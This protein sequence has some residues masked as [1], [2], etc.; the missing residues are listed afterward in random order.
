MDWW[1]LASLTEWNLVFALIVLASALAPFCFRADLLN[2]ALA[3]AMVALGAALPMFPGHALA[4]CV[5]VGPVA[6]YLLLLG[7][8][9]LSRR[10]RVISGTRDMAA[11][12]LAVAGLVMVGPGELL[13]PVASSIR[14]GAFVWV[15]LGSMYL[16]GVVLLL[17][18]LRPR[19]VIYNIS[20]DELRPVLAEVVGKLDPDARWAQDSLALPGQGIQL[21]IES[22]ARLRNVSLVSGGPVQ[23]Y[24]GWR[25]LELALTAALAGVEVPRNVRAMGLV[26]AGLILLAFVVLTVSRDP[27]AVAQAFRDAIHF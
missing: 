2:L 12:C 14:L 18:V 22:L 20:T 21:H 10:P 24:Q 15:L 17:L 19:L 26:S 5:A 8:I 27:Q 25:R 3:V 23:N 1:N 11:L 9:N 6:I 4:R 16:L 13:F 7:G